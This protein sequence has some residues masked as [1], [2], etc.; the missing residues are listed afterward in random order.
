MLQIQ[1]YMAVTGA[2]KTYIAALVGGNHFFYHEINRDDEMIS[3]II[4]MEEY[5]WKHNVIDG[6]EPVPD[7][8]TATTAYFNEKFAVSNGQTVALPEEVLSICT[9]YDSISQQIKDLENAKNA[10]SNRLKSYLMDFQ[11]GC[12]Y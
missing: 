4:A 10:V 9:E 11:N 3:K 2:K 7:G 12:R 6:V 5:F 8:S 1:H